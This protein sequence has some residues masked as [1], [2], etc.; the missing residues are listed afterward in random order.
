[1]K[2][3]M[4]WETALK[5]VKKNARRSLLT[6]LGLV[7]GT[8][9]VIT[10]VSVGRGYEKFQTEKMLPN[11]DGNTIQTTVSFNPKDESVENSNIRFFSL[12]DIEK[13]KSIAGVI[14]VEYEKEDVEKIFRTQNVTLKEYSKSTKMR[15]A[16]STGREVKYGRTLNKNDV[17]NRNKVVILSSVVATQIDTNSESLVGQSLKIGMETLEIVGV[18]E[19]SYSESSVMEIPASTYR[20]Y[21]KDSSPKNLTITLSNKYSSTLIG[22]KAVELMNSE[23]EVK[24][25]GE[26]SNASSAGMVDS[27][28]S[29]FQSLTLLISFVGA[30]SLFISGVGVMNMIYTSVSERTKEI[31]VR[32]AMGATEKAIQIQFL[33]EGLTLTLLGGL[34]GYIIGLFLAKLI[35]MLMSFTFVPDI[36]TAILAVIISVFIGV[37]FSYFPSKSATEKDIVQLVK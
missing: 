11:S 31:G 25:L 30:I 36:F 33:L 1:M 28:S 12:S 10:I 6:M 15:L 27:L 19:G 4:I 34:F 24:K 26:Y 23:G 29:M 9:A 35:S 17:V 7:I 14:K 18:Y 21:W 16:S 3:L 13:I 2:F 20:Y 37:I 5:S 8:A 32:R 22:Q